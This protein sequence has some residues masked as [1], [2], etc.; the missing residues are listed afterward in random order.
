MKNTLRKWTAGATMAA[1]LGLAAMPAM[2]TTYPALEVG[3][4]DVTLVI[5]G[6]TIETNADIGQPFI[7][8]EDRTMVPLRLVS[9][10]LGYAVVWDHLDNSV[11]ITSADGTVD[12]ELQIGSTSYTENGETGDFSRPVDMI[13]DRI[14]L[15][16]RDFMELYGTVEWDGATRTVIVTS[17][18]QPVEETTNWKFSIVSPGTGEA[19]HIVATNDV[20]DATATLLV[21]EDHAIYLEGYYVDERQTKVIDGVTYLGIGKYGVMGGFETRLFAVPDLYDG[22]ERTLDFVGQIPFRSDYT[23]ANGYIYYTDGTELGPWEPNPHVLYFAKVGDTTNEV[24]FNI[25]DFAINACTL[26]VEDGI[27]IATEPDGTRHDVLT[28]P[29]AGSVDVAHMKNVLEE[30]ETLEGFESSDTLTFEEIAC[31]P[32]ASVSEE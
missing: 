3:S 14:Y 21:P 20:L 22:A 19:A 15:P 10:E 7:S 1:V 27:L 29:E 2:A 16:A 30:N 25:S 23:V 13:N 26:S 17:D 12:V 11:S 18:S 6:K 31:M 8:T 24:H 4:T 32:G 5:N 9:Q 28:V